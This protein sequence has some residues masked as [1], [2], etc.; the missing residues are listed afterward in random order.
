[1]VRNIDI[2]LLRTFITIH[3]THSFSKSAEKLGRTQSTLSQ[4][5]KKLESL[6]GCE[7][8]KRSTRTLKT[9]Y[10]G[11]SLLPYAKKMVSLN[12][13]AIGRITNKNIS[14][15]VRLGA[16]E[17]F[18]TNHLPEV[19]FNFSQSHPSIALEVECE[20]SHNLLESFKKEDLDIVIIKRDGKS[21]I[22]GNKV[23][24]ET[25]QWTGQTHHTFSKDDTVP[26]IVSPAPCVYR[27]KMLNALERKNIKWS[28]VFTSSSIYGRVAAASAGLGITAIPEDTIPLYDNVK[29]LGKESGL[30]AIEQIDI[31][32]IENNLTKT[33]A[34]S[35]LAEY[36][37]A[38]LDR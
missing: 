4:Q 3:E 1:M 7:V 5:I 10:F 34:S 29:K 28:I 16:P 27:K 20:L 18:T 6:L 35:C 14:G 8:F 33:E 37:I 19:L 36:I 30:P 13:E 26:L 31:D 22:Y 24:K 11:E 2:D 15:I 32:L 38:A 21:K 12:D 17:A 23:W 25:L 9:T